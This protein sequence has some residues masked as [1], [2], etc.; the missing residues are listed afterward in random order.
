MGLSNSERQQRWQERQL[1]KLTA[2]VKDIVAKL[3]GMA[4]Q[5]KLKMIVAALDKH[6]GVRPEAQPTERPAD[7]ANLEVR[8][9]ELED[10]LA[11]AQWASD[12]KMRPKTVA[13]LIAWRRIGEEIK[14]GERE[15][16]K[17]RKAAKPKTEVPEDEMIETLVEKLRLK[18]QQ[19]KGY[20]TRVRK[21]DY[22][23][24]ESKTTIFVDG[25]ILRT[26]NA[27]LSPAN[28]PV[29]SRAYKR[30]EKAAQRAGHGLCYRH[31][32]IS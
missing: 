14:K 16:A 2:P 12:G 6:L 20:Q 30:A 17:A 7:T 29:D 28:F 32:R 26:I 27:A 4:D 24:R 1:V 25:D 10:K 15:V 18:E 9:R 8:I 3:T 31:A 19:L 13:E 23:V 21:L 22:L 5:G 11:V